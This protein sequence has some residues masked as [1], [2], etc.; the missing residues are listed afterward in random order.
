[1]DGKT[2]CESLTLTKTKLLPILRIW[3]AASA[4]ALLP[5]DNNKM[6]DA[7]PI[8]TPSVVN[9]ALILCA[10]TDRHAME[11]YSLIMRFTRFRITFDHTVT[12][13]DDPFCISGNIHVM[14][15]DDDGL[16]LLIE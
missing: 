13:C 6:T 12:Q 3:L 8:T 11:K 15:D 9:S 1:M 5:S 10:M 2:P 16:T 14:C 4:L 7:T